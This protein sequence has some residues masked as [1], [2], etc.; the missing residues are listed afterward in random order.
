[1]S[2]D[3]LH[4]RQIRSVHRVYSNLN[5][6]AN[7]EKKSKECKIRF[8]VLEDE[9]KQNLNDVGK[10]DIDLNSFLSERKIKHL[11]YRRTREKY[12][13]I[14][15]QINSWDLPR[16]IKV[17]LSNDLTRLCKGI[18]NEEKFIERM[19]KKVYDYMSR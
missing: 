19:N 13:P 8:L 17:G 3:N 12:E 14:R 18:I 2:I 1:M 10:L 6:V 7:K 15:K 5:S 16:N 11:A 9:K 4:I